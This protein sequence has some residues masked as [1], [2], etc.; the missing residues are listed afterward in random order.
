MGDG[1]GGGEMIEA[2]GRDRNLLL[3]YETNPQ[4]YTIGARGEDNHP[5]G[6]FQSDSTQS[7]H[8]IEESLSQATCWLKKSQNMS[9]K[10]SENVTM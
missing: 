6:D 10:I 5:I 1:Q 4:S 7:N 3:I 8:S 9:K 2:T